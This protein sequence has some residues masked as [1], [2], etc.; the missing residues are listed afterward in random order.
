MSRP[1]TRRRSQSAQD[2]KKCPASEKSPECLLRLPLG[3]TMDKSR[4]SKNPRFWSTAAVT[5]WPLEPYGLATVGFCWFD[6][7]DSLGRFRS[8]FISDRLVVL[9]IGGRCLFP[10]NIVFSVLCVVFMFLK[11]GALDRANLE[12]DKEREEGSEEGEETWKIKKNH[13][14]RTQS[15]PLSISDQS[16]VIVTIMPRHD[17]WHLF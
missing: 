1:G 11:F 15:R 6:G 4:W 16:Y 5:A 2:L 9:L 17:S 14:L 12:R 3:V 10:S 13:K 8:N 7:S